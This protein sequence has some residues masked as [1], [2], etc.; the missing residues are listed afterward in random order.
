MAEEES[1]KITDRRHRDA[2][3]N[4]APSPRDEPVPPPSPPP[5]PSA[6]PSGTDRDSTGPDLANLFVMFAS[7]ALIALGE[8]PDPMRGER[9]VDLDQAREAIDILLLLREK[10]EGNRTEQESQ[11]LEE[12][13][14][15]VQMRFVRAAKGGS[16]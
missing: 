13:L 8:A 1:F 9:S 16:G 4:P 6:P 11:L 14:Y 15:D 5:T 2:A 12:I 10:T 7:S 3:A